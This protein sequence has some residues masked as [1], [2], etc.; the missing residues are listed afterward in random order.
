[1]RQYSD[2][3]HSGVDIIGNSFFGLVFC[4]CQCSHWI[5]SRTGKVQEISAYK[6]GIL[7]DRL[8][9]RLVSNMQREV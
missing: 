1:M 3:I 9:D 5:V 2:Y 4:E 7:S 6:A 8:V